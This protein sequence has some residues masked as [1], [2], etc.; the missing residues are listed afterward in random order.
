MGIRFIFSLHLQDIPEYHK[1]AFR[2]IAE[3]LEGYTEQCVISFID[4][5]GKLQSRVAPYGIRSPQT[6]E[7]MELAQF[8]SETAE[9][10]RI[11]IETCTEKIDLS[12]FGIYPTHCI[13]AALIS[14]LTGKDLQVLKDPSQRAECGCCESVDI[15]S[16]VWT[17]QQQI[18]FLEYFLRGGKSG[19]IL[20][21]NCPSW[22]HNVP[23]GAYND[24]VCVDGLQRITAFQQFIRN[25]IPV[26]GSYYREYTDS[27]K[28]RY[29]MKVNVNDLKTKAEVLRWYIEMN[30]GGTPHTNAEIE[31]VKR[32]LEKAE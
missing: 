3:A 24:Y 1:K 23:Y 28:L 16:Y 12:M 2:S 19:T 10:H 27:M 9:K 18:A 17:E 30:A 14:Q 7:I 15:G 13:D 22:H 11:R 20:Y 26:F 4:I 32:I 5:Y 21:F 31:C 29:T 25:E 6:E 8:I